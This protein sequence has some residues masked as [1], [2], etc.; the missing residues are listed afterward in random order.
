MMLVYRKMSCSRA[1]ASGWE[2]YINTFMKNVFIDYIKRCGTA[3]SV[4]FNVIFFGESNQTFSARNWHWKRNSKPN[5]VWLINVA[6][7]D[8]HHCMESWV[9][10]K[11]RKDF[12]SKTKE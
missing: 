7:N 5:I 9:Y 1:L 4:F 8:S 11:V 6:F 12:G 2:F 3:F 10:W